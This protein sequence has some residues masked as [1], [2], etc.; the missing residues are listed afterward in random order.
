MAIHSINLRAVQDSVRGKVPKYKY[1]QSLQVNEGLSRA[2][3]SHVFSA[4]W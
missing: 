3:K 1:I 4:S 2:E